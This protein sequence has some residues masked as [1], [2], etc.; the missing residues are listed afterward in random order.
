MNKLSKLIALNPL[1]VIWLFLFWRRRR[2]GECY[3][4]EGPRTMTAGVSTQLLFASWSSTLV[5]IASPTH[6]SKRFQLTSR[7]LLERE[8][9]TRC[10]Y[11]G[12][13]LRDLNPAPLWHADSSQKER[14]LGVCYW[15]RQAWE[16]WNTTLINTSCLCKLNHFLPTGIIT[17]F[18]VP[19]L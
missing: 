10:C 8:L 6:Q 13:S 5:S 4:G 19:F 3:E 16:L 7:I 18:P 11:L 15:W 1:K 17:F 9:R 14:L 2:K 12:V